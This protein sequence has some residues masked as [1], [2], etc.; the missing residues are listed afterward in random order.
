MNFGLL[1]VFR[2]STSPLSVVDKISI[3]I[4]T[5]GMNRIAN[6]S[7]IRPTLFP[8][9]LAGTN[10]S[11]SSKCSRT[12]FEG[13]GPSHGR[14]RPRKDFADSVLFCD[15]G[16]RSGLLH[17]T[18]KISGRLWYISTIAQHPWCSQFSQG[19]RCSKGNQATYLT[20]R[21]YWSFLLR[22]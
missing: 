20:S 11:A 9:V 12:R 10:S 1:L 18:W 6:G 7:E 17:V 14:S 13:C 3:A 21:S 16:I 2:I 15:A 8:L 22:S 19:A 4:V 5:R